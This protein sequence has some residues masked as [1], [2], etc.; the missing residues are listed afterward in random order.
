MNEAIIEISDLRKSF[1]GQ[2]KPALDGLW[3]TI[4]HG[5]MTGMVGPD[6]AGKTT[7]MR[8]LVG[9]VAPDSGSILIEGLDPVKEGESIRSMSGYMPQKFG[10]YEDLSVLENLRLYAD[11]RGLDAERRK[12]KFKTLLEFT[13]LSDFTSRL[14]GRL[15]GGMKQKLG[16][17]CVLLGD[18][19]FLFLD[20]PSVGV[21]PISRRELW[22]MVRTLS[23]QGLTVVWGTS[24]LD[25]AQKCDCVILLCQG[26]KL[27]SGPPNDALTNL[28][29]RCFKLI[30]VSEKERR[31]TLLSL[32]KD[33][34]V[35]DCTIVGSDIR[36]VK[37]KGA[38]LAGLS[39]SSQWQPT[40]PSFEDAFLELLGGGPHGDSPLAQKSLTRE[41]SLDIVVEA[42]NLTK[43]FGDFVAVKD[44]S[45]QIRRGE[46]FGLIGPNG[47]GKST[48]FKM[49]CGLSRPT[50][51]LAL[52]AGIDLRSS[53]S[54]ARSRIGYMAQKFSLYNQLSVSQN[55]N[56]FSGVYGLHG[57]EKK[58]IVNK[59]LEIFDLGPYSDQNADCLPLG[60]KQ[61]LALACAIMH[62]PDVLFLDEPTSGVDPVTRREFWLH[63]N[64]LATEGVTI[65][66]T[67]HFMEE[68]EYCDRIGLIHHGLNI[69]TGTPD[70]LKSHVRS[71]Q[72]PSP[73]MED[74]FIGLIR[75][76]GEERILA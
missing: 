55:L 71:P 76:K 31:P 73:T 48:T 11:I 53:P 32:L 51:G 64:Y 59:M 37:N 74:A 70:E 1:K 2:Q 69:A 36:I 13:S 60:F 22:R 47:A 15:S 68:A 42:K 63:L 67:T 5:S 52:I 39:P 50:S 58:T 75:E 26:Q 33:D 41:T 18:P 27:Y 72:I 30:K 3:A 65:M 56:F 45:F 54:K 62:Q 66:V 49:M 57:S 6:G 28:K 7:L 9:L 20:E 14:A 38:S 10:L 43:C 40:E 17:A 4:S 19:K 29:G 44:N 16:L 23:N 21:D 35:M 61:R 46:I 34:S 12:E 25:E 8:L 24:Y